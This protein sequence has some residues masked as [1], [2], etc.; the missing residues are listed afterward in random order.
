ML[1]RRWEPFAELR[2]RDTQMD[3]MW[4]HMFRPYHT[5]PRLGGA[6]GHPAVDV[7]QDKDNVVVRATLPGIKREDVDVT[8]ADDTLTIKG[9][10]K[11]LS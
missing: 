7:Y 8:V 2:K 9:E 11:Q 3:H 4:R 6:G 10:R 5:W 1:L